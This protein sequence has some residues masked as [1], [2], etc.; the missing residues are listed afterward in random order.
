MTHVLAVRARSS[1][2][3][4]SCGV[5]RRDTDSIALCKNVSIAMK[6]APM[7]YSQTKLVK[8]TK[9]RQF[10]NKTGD[11]W[12]ILG[13]LAML[14]LVHILPKKILKRMVFGKSPE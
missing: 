11:R 14:V 1:S 5:S 6:E 10:V 13:A 4:V 9:I 8:E 3:A 12:G 2:G 7:G